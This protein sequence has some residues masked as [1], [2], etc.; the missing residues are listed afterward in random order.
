LILRPQSLHQ[1]RNPISKS[2]ALFCRRRCTS[3]T[4]GAVLRHAV[5][6][7]ARRHISCVASSSRAQSWRTWHLGPSYCKEPPPL[8]APYSECTRRCH[9]GRVSTDSCACVGSGWVRQFV[10]AHASASRA[11]VTR[12]HRLH[13]SENGWR[14]VDFGIA[15]RRRNSLTGPGGNEIARALQRLDY[16][17]A[18]LSLW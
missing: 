15:C 7:A 9:S 10:H 8:C 17:A 11:L 3:C 14:R 5:M 2:P 1:M 13:A 18:W 4:L 16:A 6:Q 12:L